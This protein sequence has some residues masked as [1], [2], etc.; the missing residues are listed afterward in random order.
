MKIAY[1][2]E[3]ENYPYCHLLYCLETKTVNVDLPNY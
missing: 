3:L 2:R 1:S